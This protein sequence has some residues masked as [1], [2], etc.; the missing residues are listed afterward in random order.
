M[1]YLAIFKDSLREALDSKI[2]YFTLALSLVI[3][4]VIGSVS[5]RPLSVQEQFVDLTQNLNRLMAYVPQGQGLRFDI[6]NYEAEND[7]PE[8]WQGTYRF[9]YLISAPNA[10]QLDTAKRNGLVPTVGAFQAQLQQA[11]WIDKLTVRE[12]PAANPGEVRY[13]VEI[14]GTKVTDRRGWVHEPALLFGAVPMSLLQGPLSG[15]I[16]VIADKGIG[17]FGAAVTMLLSIVITAFFIPNMLRKGT[18][19]LL[20]AKPIHRTTLLLFK[21][22]GGMTFMFLNTAVVMLGLWFVLGLQTGVWLGSLLLCVLV[23][24]FQFAIFY[25]VST[26]MAVTT[27]SPIVAI[28]AAVAM[29]AVLFLF[30][31]VYRV[32][33]AIRPE[34]FAGKMQEDVVPLPSWVYTTVDLAHMILPHYK[35]L[36]LLTTRIIRQDMLDP[37]SPEAKQVDDHMDTIRWERSIPITLAFIGIM[38][39]LS[40]WRFA[41]HD[42]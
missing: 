25:S 3:V 26:L 37:N 39:G 33:D 21:F 22:L 42:Y 4:L 32:V 31:H 28:L 34:K 41:R 27:R 9:V 18:I 2:I 19:D 20:L 40:C 23:F 13:L 16:E 30:G 11:K 15:Q 12:Q 10:A 8:P 17:F 6:V 1:K 5:F 14:G 35:D 36:D 38:L 7:V 24:T 29:W